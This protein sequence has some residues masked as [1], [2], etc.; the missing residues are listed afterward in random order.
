ML[1]VIAHL[2]DIHLSPNLHLKIRRR[3]GE[4]FGSAGESVCVA[5]R[6]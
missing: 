1:A 3:V 4:E 6:L 2:L 5:A